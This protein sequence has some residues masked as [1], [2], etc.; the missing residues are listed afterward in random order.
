[1]TRTP[2]SRPKGEGHQA[3]LLSAALRRK[4]AE[5]ISVGTYSAWENTTTLRLLGGARGA[6]AP[7]G[8][9]GAGAYCVATRTAC[10]NGISPEI[11]G[12][13]WD[14]Q[15]RTFGDVWCGARFFF[16]RSDAL[17]VIQQIVQSTEGANEK[18]EINGN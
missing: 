8:R 15:R 13:L 7:T 10:L 6:W 14:L 1:M 3:A 9:K 17:H 18:R 12:L 5:A 2:L 11:A 16:N 4:A